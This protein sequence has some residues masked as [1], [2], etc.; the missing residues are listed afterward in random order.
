MS[1]IHVNIN[2][3]FPLFIF[4]NIDSHGLPWAPQRAPGSHQPLGTPGDPRGPPG[5]PG[6]PRKF[7]RTPTPIIHRSGVW[8]PRGCPTPVN[9]KAQPKVRKYAFQRALGW[10][11]PH[12]PKNNQRP[13]HDLV[14]RPNLYEE[15]YRRA[16]GQQTWASSGLIY[17]YAI[18]H[19]N[20][21]GM[22]YV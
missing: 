10:H 12:V 14:R 20:S 21:N 15:R 4:E 2:C 13:Q 17:T 7:P 3:F 6:N 11:N 18:H 1:K 9:S 16:G 5:T 19:T 8:D 22:R